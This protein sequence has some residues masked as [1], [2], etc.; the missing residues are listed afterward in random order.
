MTLESGKVGE[1]GG[2]VL[3][4][5]GPVNSVGDLVSSESCSL[6]EGPRTA[7]A[8]ERSFSRVYPL[9]FMTGGRIPEGFFA[10]PEA[11]EDC[12]IQPQDA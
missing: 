11:K 7:R 10:P 9:V 8:L 1:G 2:A 4:E 3:A 5:E 12:M 6:V